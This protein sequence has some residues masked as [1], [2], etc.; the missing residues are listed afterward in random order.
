MRDFT[1]NDNH[2]RPR[3]EYLARLAALPDFQLLRE[4]ED[5]IWL[6]A[7]ANNNPRSDFHWHVDACYDEWNRRGKLD[8]YDVAY[9]RARETA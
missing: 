8:Q 5:K 6:S 2:G 4:T 3:Q 9:E 7:Y 1:G